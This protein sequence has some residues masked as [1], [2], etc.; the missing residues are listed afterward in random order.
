MRSSSLPAAG[1]IRPTG[2]VTQERRC[3][4]SSH[5]YTI[6]CRQAEDDLKA[7]LSRLL[8]GRI[9]AVRRNA[10]ERGHGGL[11]GWTVNDDDEIILGSGEVQEQARIAL[12]MSAEAWD[13]IKSGSD[14]KDVITP[15]EIL[16]AM[17]AAGAT[18]RGGQRRGRTGRPRSEESLDTVA[19]PTRT[20]LTILRDAS[21]YETGILRRRHQLPATGMT[22]SDAHGMTIYRNNPED[23]YEKGF[24]VFEW[25]FPLPEKPFADSATIAKAL[26]YRRHL[27]ESKRSYPEQPQAWPFSSL[28]TADHEGTHYRL[29]HMSGAYAWRE[30]DDV[31]YD[32]MHP[33]GNFDVRATTEALVNSLLGRLEDDGL[34]PSELGM[35]V[36]RSKPLDRDGQ[37]KLAKLEQAL[38]AKED[39]LNTMISISKMAKTARAK[40][41][42]AEQVD[43][44]SDEIVELEEAIAEARSETITE[45]VGPPELEI[46]TLSDLLSVTL[47]TAGDSVDPVIA[48]AWARVIIDGRVDDCWDDASPWGTFSYRARLET[49]HGTILTDLITFSVGNTSYGKRG[50]SPAVPRRLRRVLD[51]RMTEGWEIEELAAKMARPNRPRGRGIV[52][53]ASLFGD[54]ASL[55]TEALGCTRQ[56]ASALVDHPIESTRAAVWAMATGSPMPLFDGMSADE[57]DRHLEALWDAYLDPKATWPTFSAFLGGEAHRREC[58]RWVFTHSAADPAM[59]APYTRLRQAMGWKDGLSCIYNITLPVTPKG[60]PQSVLL[61]KWTTTG[62]NDWGRGTIYVDTPDGRRQVPEVPDEEKRLRIRKCPH[63]QT[64]TLLQPIPCPEGG[65]DPV[66]C[67]TCLRTPEDP[68]HRFPAEY[69]LAFEGPWGRDSTAKQKPG[70]RGGTRIGQSPAMPSAVRSKRSRRSGTSK[71]AIQGSGRRSERAN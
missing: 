54:L 58:A 50:G 69:L 67:V 14:K 26:E 17:S 51:M 61:E 5:Q 68:S 35:C 2:P 6:L 59:G 71:K 65:C 46:G 49:S 30:W 19:Q 12:R 37:L 39:E 11:L 47:D 53:P 1:P 36:T 45:E 15:Q 10:W 33:V 27:L 56:L 22:S 48:K 64:R 4:P 18:K 9:Y 38:S 31:N 16:A 55:A 21:T 63:C 43:V 7:I 52:T 32:N 60:D 29:R 3:A 34:T 44:V 62:R 70:D 13:S 41:R 28:F 24:I 25:T 42:F 8:A 23:P 20:L 57:R 66:L 40:L